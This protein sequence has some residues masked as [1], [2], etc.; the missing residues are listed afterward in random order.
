MIKLKSI[1]NEHEMTPKDIASL[2]QDAI[3]SIFDIDKD[4][5]LVT[6]VYHKSKDKWA[7]SDFRA[8]SEV[9]I[10]IIFDYKNDR[11]IA[12]INFA[13]YK[14]PTTSV[15]KDLKYGSKE[16]KDYE[17]KLRMFSNEPVTRDL[18]KQR[19]PL[20]N[21][22]AWVW[23]KTKSWGQCGQ[24]WPL[25]HDM[26]SVHEDDADFIGSVNEKDLL[27]FIKQLKKL[28]DGNEGNRESPSEPTVPDPSLTLTPA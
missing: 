18:L 10:N 5:T 15:P 14:I 25:K 1:I 2:I 3:V 23:K 16:Y 21:Y 24:K 6:R 17:V 13:Y 28:C 8:H 19:S 11:F 9:D 12:G 27:S 22:F 26:G 20:L 7:Y 4:Q